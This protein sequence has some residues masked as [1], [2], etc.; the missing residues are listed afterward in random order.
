MGLENDILSLDVACSKGTYIRTLMEDIGKMLGCGAH[1]IELRRTGFAHFD[2]TDSITFEK[3][4]TLK[5]DAFEALDAHI[6]SA[7]TMLPNFDSVILSAEQTS[8]IK[9]GRKVVYGDYDQAQKLKLFDE[10]QQFI[11]MG[12]SNLEGEVLPKRLF[13]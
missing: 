11:G 6:L 3:L 9:L 7:D 13:V 8:D 1:V 5:G 10:N 4:E 2:L 12:E